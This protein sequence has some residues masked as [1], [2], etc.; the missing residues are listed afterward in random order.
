MIFK[1]AS[2][3]AKPVY[4]QIVDQ[5][6]YA[7]A[8]G[9]LREGD[10]LPSIRDVA[11]Q[12]RVNRNTVAKAYAELE[13]EGVILTRAGKGTTIRGQSALDVSKTRIRQTLSEQID[14]LLASAHQFQLSED[15][16]LE[17]IRERLDRLNLKADAK[18]PPPETSAQKR[19]K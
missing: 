7:L 11:V 10:R 9:D 4:Q 17:L 19:R 14:D 3:S 6:K 13:R 16:I 8:R 12:T 2:D 5:V 18:P 1:I 15:E